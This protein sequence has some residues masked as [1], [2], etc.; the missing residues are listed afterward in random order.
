MQ[1]QSIITLVMIGELQT[2]SLPGLP[3]IEKSNCH[4]LF[5]GIH[6]NDLDQFGL[7]ISL[8]WFIS[9]LFLFF[10]FFSH[11]IF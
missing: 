9:S 2:K 7:V 5:M 6:D 8:S 4:I 3:E 1:R 10:L 11:L